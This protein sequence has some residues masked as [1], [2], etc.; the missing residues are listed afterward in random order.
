M[1]G[2]LLYSN[3][4]QSLKMMGNTCGFLMTNEFINV[5]FCPFGYVVFILYIKLY[6]YTVGCS[7]CL[8][9]TMLTPILYIKAYTCK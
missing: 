3:D 2:L 1:L 8:F 4:L 5:G 7:K 9:P 6:Y